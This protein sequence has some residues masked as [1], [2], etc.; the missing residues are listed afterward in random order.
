MKVFLRT[1]KTG[2]TDWLS[3]EEDLEQLPT[4]GDFVVRSSQGHW[5]QVKA[6]LH[7]PKSL[8][9]HFDAEVLAVAVDE[10]SELK[11]LGLPPTSGS[12]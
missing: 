6:V 8:G 12:R 9:S 7:I 10:E 11:Q 1:I 2:R 4:P 5:F 3:T